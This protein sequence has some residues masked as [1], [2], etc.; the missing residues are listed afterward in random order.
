M[1]PVRWAALGAVLLAAATSLGC[2]IPG[3]KHGAISFEAYDLSEDYTPTA[4]WLLALDDP[5]KQMLTPLPG[6]VLILFNE[7]LQG[8]KEH[9]LKCYRL[10][11]QDRRISYPPQPFVLGILGK[12]RMGGIGLKER[13]VVAFAPDRTPVL[14]TE[15]DPWTPF[16]GHYEIKKFYAAP[17]AT[18]GQARIIFCKNQAACEQAYI[19]RE[20]SLAGE[21][22]RP[23]MQSRVADRI[24]KAGP[25]M[26]QAVAR[27]K[28]LLD[29]DRLMV[30]R[31]M[32]GIVASGACGEPLP[33]LQKLLDE[34]IQ[35][36]SN[37]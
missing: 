4:E 9:V 30:Y 1:Q 18:V 7:S 21:W 2:A 13:G 11:T 27:S 19:E 31:Q 22:T 37:M 28:E 32:Q 14:L 25:A 15:E 26:V 16:N 5:P 20:R 35:A 29:R 12:D 36:I 8:D 33:G 23:T 24:K 3:V 6:A 17:Y 10:D 34:S